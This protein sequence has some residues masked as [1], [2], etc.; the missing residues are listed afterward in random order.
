[1]CFM[2]FLSNYLQSVEKPLTL[3]E[4]LPLILLITIFACFHWYI[5]DFCL[6]ISYVS[7]LLKDLLANTLMY[8]SPYRF[9][10]RFNSK[11]WLGLSK[12]LCPVRRNRLV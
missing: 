9:S 3:Q 6:E 4:P 1:M 12:T 10:I 7:L 8:S 5:E 11:L 2:L